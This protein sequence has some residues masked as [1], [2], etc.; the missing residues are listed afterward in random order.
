MNSTSYNHQVSEA[1]D[2]LKR[3]DPVLKQVIEVIGEF[4]L[5]IKDDNYEG[6]VR[7]VVG[8]QLSVIA[9]RSI[10]SRVKESLNNKITP[11]YVIAT[12]DIVFYKSGLSR[13]KTKTIKLIA[14]EITQQKLDLHSIAQLNNE[15]I[16]NTLIKIKG[17]G[18]WTVHN[19]LIFV[20]GRLDVLPIDDIAFKR[21]IRLNYRL[22]DLPSID[23]IKR[24]SE[25]WGEYP[26]I[27]SWYLWETINRKIFS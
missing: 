5:L 10:F 1:I 9:A 11:K 6:L 16:F 27:A 2:L 12:E 14:E 4:N 22:A 17:I 24:I 26:T 20:L 7:I 21:A 25:N 13:S 8:Q 3:K 23:T 18:P 15:D 19:Y